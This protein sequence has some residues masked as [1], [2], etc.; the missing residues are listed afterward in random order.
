MR[1]RVNLAPSEEEKDAVSRSRKKVRV[2]EGNFSSEQTLP[3][4]DKVWM[5]DAESG[6]S[7]VQAK[8]GATPAKT[9]TKSFKEAV[10]KEKDKV[11]EEEED[12]WCNDKWKERIK[13]EMTAMGP[14]VIIPDR[15]HERLA[16]R[17]KKALFVKLLGRMMS[18]EY[19]EQKLKQLWAKQGDVEAMDIGS[20][21]F[22]V[23]FSN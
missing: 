12:W 5:H 7:K 4:R 20:G 2:D 13:V 23:Q 19:L 1:E 16:Q 14:N 15:E 21:F 18:P 22:A 3:P 11:D 17:W 9:T 8:E 10:T 6:E